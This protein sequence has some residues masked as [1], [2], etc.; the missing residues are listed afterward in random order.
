MKKLLKI[1]FMYVLLFSYNTAISQDQDNPWAISLGINAVDYWPVGQPDPQGDLFDEFFNVNDHWNIFPFIS[2]IEISRS[3]GRNLSFSVIGSLNRIDKFGDLRTGPN[4]SL[5]TNRVPDLTYY[6]I[7]GAI[8]YS[9]TNSG[10]IEPFI[11]G[12]GGYTWLDKIGSGTLNGSIGVKYWF[13]P[14]FAFQL[15]STYKHVFEVYGFRHFQHSVSISHKFGGDKDTDRDGI[16]D[17]EDN[18]PD[19]PGLYAFNGCPDTDNDGV[20]D[21]DDACPKVKGLEAFNGCPDSDNDGVEDKSDRCPDVPGLTTLFGC[22]DSDGDN[23]TDSRDKC[24]NVSGPNENNG[25]PWPDADGD[26]TIDRYDKCPNTKGLVENNGCPKLSE[27]DKTLINDYAKTLLFSP[28]RSEIK[29]ESKLVLLDILRLL[30]TNPNAKFNIIGHTDSIGDSKFNQQLSEERASAVRDYLILSGIDRSRLS[31]AGYGE[32]KPI[33]DN[34]TP[35]GRKQ[36]RRVEIILV[37]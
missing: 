31:S 12:G 26:G 6:G 23:I 15:Q 28:G 1:I 2:R 9:F 8:N 14:K 33:A 20:A 35:D 10:K 25:C 16:P 34:R 22:P 4:G 11:S 13:A 5:Q 30:N 21:P 24:P 36:N 7:D 32:D 18:C 27:Q 17:E 29:D 3:F 37:N 19:T